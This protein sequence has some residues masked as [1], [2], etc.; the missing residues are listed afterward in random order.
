MSQ[1]PMEEG[2]ADKRRTL[3]EN[4]CKCNKDLEMTFNRCHVLPNLVES[5]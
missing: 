4:D 2:H 3:E 1:N 5:Y